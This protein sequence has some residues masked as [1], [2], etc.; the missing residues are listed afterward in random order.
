MTRGNKAIRCQERGKQIK[1][2]KRRGEKRREEENRII[3]LEVNEQRGK[4]R[5]R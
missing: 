4:E 2:M 3:Q 5:S 1:S